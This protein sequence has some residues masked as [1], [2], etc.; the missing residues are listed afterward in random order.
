MSTVLFV[1]LAVLRRLVSTILGRG[2]STHSETTRLL[3]FSLVVVLLLGTKAH[4]LVVDEGL[5][6]VAIN[7]VVGE[8]VDLDQPAIQLADS[9]QVGVVGP[10][11]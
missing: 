4:D 11:D 9:G 6:G 7:G 1:G 8:I 2:A 3:L 10:E 5:V